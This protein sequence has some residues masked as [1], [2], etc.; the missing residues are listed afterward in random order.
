ML[1]PLGVALFALGIALAGGILLSHVLAIAQF[2]PILGSLI[3]L[4][5]GIDYALFI[6][7]RARQEVKRGADVEEAVTTALNTSGRAVLFA[8]TTVCIALL[9]MLILQLSFLNGVAI[10]AS[11]TVLITMLASVTL[12]PALLGFQGNHVLSRRERRSLAKNGPE[13]TV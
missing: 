11:I 7:T 12:L 4:G 8:G 10:T 6:V 13:P 1:L 2:A 9:G 3:G 5:V